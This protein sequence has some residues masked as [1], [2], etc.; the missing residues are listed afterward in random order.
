MSELIEEALLEGEEKMEK[1]VE[2]AREEFGNIRSGRA[3]VGMFASIMVEYYGAPTPLQQ[4]ASISIPEA[5][6]VIINPFDKSAKTA[7][8]HAIR[9]SD[10]GVNPTDDGN[11]LRCVL[12]ILT[13]ERRRDYVKMARTKAEEARVSV[14]GVRRKTKDVL[15]KIKKDGDAG[16]D[17]VKRGEDELDSLTKKYVDQI[18]KMLDI[19]E[20]ELLEI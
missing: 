13:E 6:T 5:R 14:R 18:D 3:N 12:P 9:E 7:I 15:D 17:D 16:E 19:K 10:L 4:L 11:I 2:R 1:A 20:K 8:D